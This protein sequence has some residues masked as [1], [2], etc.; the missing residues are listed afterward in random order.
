MRVW[1]VVEGF[2]KYNTGSR[3]Y[4]QGIVRISQNLIETSP[5]AKLRLRRHDLVRI[6]CNGASVLTLFRLLPVDEKVICLEYDDRLKIGIQEKG[7]TQ[8]LDISKANA[9][10]MFRYYWRHSNPS[11]MIGFRLSVVLSFVSAMFGFLLGVAVLPWQ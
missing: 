4:G 7:M 9:L 2:S 1:A 11:V 5:L 10:A 6:S 8:D 3:D